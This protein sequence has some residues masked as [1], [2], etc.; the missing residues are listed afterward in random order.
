M[1][2]FYLRVSILFCIKYPWLWVVVAFLGWPHK[3]LLFIYIYIYIKNTH[4]IPVE[5]SF[6]MA[7]FRVLV[8][9][10]LYPHLWP[11]WWIDKSALVFYVLVPNC[12]PVMSPDLYSLVVKHGNGQS[13]METSIYSLQSG[14]PLIAK[15]VNMVYGRYNYS[16]IMGFINQLI[17]GGA[18]HWMILCHL[19]LPKSILHLHAATW[20]GCYPINYISNVVAI[21]C[22][23]DMLSWMS[24]SSSDYPLAINSLPWN[25]SG[26]HRHIMVDHLGNAKFPWVLR[27]SH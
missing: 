8:I 22:C 13:I 10:Q 23:I 12:I 7:K 19:W 5:S 25:I 16:Y 20:A 18:L 4:L 15:L 27:Y 11:L 14:A 2:D 1:A 6:Q 9:I 26:F 24:P 3:Q 21:P 17:T